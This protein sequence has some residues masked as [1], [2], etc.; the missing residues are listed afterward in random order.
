MSCVGS[1]E[2][3]AKR[4]TIWYCV[5]LGNSRQNVWWYIYIFNILHKNNVFPEVYYNKDNIFLYKKKTRTRHKSLV[6][7]ICSSLIVHSV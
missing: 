5:M 7:I 4:M 6:H 2:V 1:R 3:Y